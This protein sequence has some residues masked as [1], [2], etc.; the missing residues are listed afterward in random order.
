[1]KKAS[2]KKAEVGE[3][4]QIRAGRP[5]TQLKDL[6]GNKTQSFAP[7]DRK[8]GSLSEVEYLRTRVDQ[9]VAKLEHEFPKLPKTML[10]RVLLAKGANVSLADVGP[11]GTICAT[12]RITDLLAG[13][14][15]EESE[16][17]FISTRN[18]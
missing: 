8:L 18:Y 2:A 12:Q 10:S 1:M 15:S 3:Y 17:I 13:R 14:W 11:L 4:A 9:L 7:E 5:T 16:L 6:G